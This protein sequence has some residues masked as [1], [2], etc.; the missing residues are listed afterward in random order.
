MASLN[1]PPQYYAAEKKY[2]DARTDEEKLAA[3]QEMLRLVPK[4]KGSQEIIKQIRN[5][6]S[7]IKKNIIKEELK[8]RAAAK[9]AG[10]FVKK[11]GLQVVLLG[12]ANAGKSALFNLVTNAR[13]KST[14]VPF[15]TTEVIP[16]IM[17]HEKVQIQVLDTPSVTESNKFML[18]A[19]ARNADLA[20]VLFSEEWEKDFF[21]ESGAKLFFL[22][23]RKDYSLEKEDIEKIKKKIYEAL[24]VIRVF[25]KNRRGKA[26]FEKPIVLKRGTTVRDAAKEVHKDFSQNLKYARVWG[27]AKFAGMQV[28]PDY[29]LEDEDVVEFHLRE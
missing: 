22:H 13:S 20:V 7:A 21:K 14:S 27:S 16:G 26:D 9:K 11:Q 24:S 1:A 29:V 12:F 4:H 25:T 18:F 10:D 28:S 19:L 2:S 23:P 5:K 15:E 17:E 8:K 3:L 6:I